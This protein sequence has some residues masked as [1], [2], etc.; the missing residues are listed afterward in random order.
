MERE[1]VMRD[2]RGGIFKNLN[3][4]MCGKFESLKCGISGYLKVCDFLNVEFKKIYSYRRS[5]NTAAAIDPTEGFPSASHCLSY[6]VRVL[7]ANVPYSGSL[8]NR[9]R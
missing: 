3:L 8:G 6:K 5:E 4:N 9:Q 7:L 1:R 2:E